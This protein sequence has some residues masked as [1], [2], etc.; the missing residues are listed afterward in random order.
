MKHGPY[1]EAIFRFNIHIGKN[2]P[3][4]EIPVKHPSDYSWSF[5]Q[6]LFFLTCR[7]LFSRHQSS[8]QKLTQSPAS[9]RPSHLSASGNVGSTTSGT[10][11]STSRDHCWSLMTA[12][13][14]T[15]L[16]LNCESQ[17]KRHRTF[18][19]PKITFFFANAGPSTTLSSSTPRL[20][21]A[22]RIPS[23]TYMRATSSRAIHT[24]CASLLTTQT[25]TEPSARPY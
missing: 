3:R 21:S 20:P 24:T 16:L 4:T 1:K 12:T 6:G 11:C 18:K 8:I 17:N 10:S 13:R 14:S 2:F 9:W 5:Q 25:S 7:L 19:V 23:C 22:S 15:K